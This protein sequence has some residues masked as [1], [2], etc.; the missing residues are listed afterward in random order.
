M[1]SFPFY[2]HLT[3]ILFTYIFDASI[4]TTQT[5][6]TIFGNFRLIIFVLIE[7]RAFIIDL[8]KPTM[9]GR[10]NHYITRITGRKMTS[11]GTWMYA[12]FGSTNL[13]T[14]QTFGTRRFALMKIQFFLN[15]H[16][17]LN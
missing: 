6:F 7:F 15:D 4:S 8:I 16:A 14:L 10:F 9:A 2:N 12:S 17:M 1:F 5:L 11:F 13:A 3:N